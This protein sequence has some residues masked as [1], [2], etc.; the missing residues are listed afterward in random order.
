MAVKLPKV[1]ATRVT[2]EEYKA[3]NDAAQK[4]G[5]AVSA[6]IRKK[7]GLKTEA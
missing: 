6:Y 1:V 4:E 5:L 2:A 3:V 7:L